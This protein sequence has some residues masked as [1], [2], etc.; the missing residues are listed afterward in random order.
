[1]LSKS[2]KLAAL[3]CA[4]YVPVSYAAATWPA[5]SDE[6]ED[7]MFLNN[8]LHARAFSAAVVPC[9]S[10][11]AGPGRDAS[12]EWLRTAFHDM[13]P[14]SA[15]GV[16]KG[17][18]GLDASIAF[19][20]GG[21]ATE[22]I[23]AAFGTTLTTFSPFLT[24]RSSMADLIALGVYTSVRA[25]SGPVVAIR[26]GR[27]DA[28]AS[29]PLGV[30]QPQNGIGTFQN[31]FARM[32]FSNTEMIQVVACGHTMGGVHAVNFPNIV[33]AGTVPNDYQFLDSTRGFDSKIAVEYIAKN[34]SDALVQGPCASSG[35]C[36]D[37]AIFASDGNA[38]V[39]AM[40]DP[41][42][43]SNVCATVLQKMIELV[44]SGVTLTDPITIYEVKPYNLQ[45]SVLAGGTQLSFTGEIRVRTTSQAVSSVTLVY[46]DRTGASSCGAACTITTTLKGTAS[47]FDD[48]FSVRLLS[49][50]K[51][52]TILIHS[53]ITVS[54]HS[55]Q[56]PHQSLHLL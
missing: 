8:G 32:G 26:T 29:G 41:T 56:L 24:S 25:C 39:A 7:I 17:I 35:R 11:Q 18:G 21:V 20:L 37:L 51:K 46:V 23:G 44:P 19:E 16:N 30:P 54:P 40:Q 12:A 9:G 55:S 22:D 10:S 48:T 49:L 15:V 14:G 31:Q 38:T 28:T 47:G 5:S 45:L 33:T 1:M 43:F 36:S 53:S 34:G 6:L 4:Y 3:L 13:A 42:A 2:I 27:K 52:R 50:L